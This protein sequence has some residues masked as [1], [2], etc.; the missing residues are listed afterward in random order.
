M[1]CRRAQNA[2]ICCRSVSGRSARTGHEAAID[3]KAVPG[4]DAETGGRRAAEDAAVPLARAGGI[5][6]GDLRHAGD[7]RGERL[8]VMVAEREGVDWLTA[9]ER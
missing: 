1:W 9:G 8:G 7:V 3:L 4:V 2:T 6:R 5:G